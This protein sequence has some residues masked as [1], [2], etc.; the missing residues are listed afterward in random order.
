MSKS[1]RKLW[2]DHLAGRST[3]STQVD[4]KTL[5]RKTPFK[6]RILGVDPSLRGTGL[7]VLECEGSS[8]KLLYSETLFAFDTTPYQNG[9]VM[10]KG[11]SNKPVPQ[12]ALGMLAEKLAPIVRK[13]SYGEACSSVPLYN[14]S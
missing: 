1:S 12:L 2:A 3:R 4:T 6:G 8:Y 9:L 5:L 10:I 13:L 11:C 7:A 14:K